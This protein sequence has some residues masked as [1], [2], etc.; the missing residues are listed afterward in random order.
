MREYD[1]ALERQICSVH[2]FGKPRKER[3]LPLGASQRELKFVGIR[4]ILLQQSDTLV[5]EAFGG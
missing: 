5:L 4:Q 3:A 2:C 1:D